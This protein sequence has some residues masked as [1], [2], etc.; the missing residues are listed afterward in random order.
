MSSTDPDSGRAKAGEG[1]RGDV[2]RAW[3]RTK[4]SVAR[5]APSERGGAGGAG[6]GGAGGGAALQP[7]RASSR[8]RSCGSGRACWRAGGDAGSELV[9]IRYGRMLVSPFT[10]Y[11]GAARIMASDLAATPHS[12]FGRRR[13]AM[14]ICRTSACSHRR[15][16]DWCSTSTTSTRRCRGRGS[17]TSSGWRRAWWSRRA[18]TAIHA[19]SAAGSCARRSAATARRCAASPTMTQSGGVVLA[20]GRRRADRPAPQPDVNAKMLEARREDARQGPHARQHAGVL[21]AH[22]GGRRR[23]AD[24]QRPAADRAR[25]GTRART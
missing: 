6:A 22:P 7:R 10:F 9:P 19:G 13:A 1:P 25:R 14:R 20:A 3:A 15:N 8:R 23:A 21:Q 5:G 17:G 4:P 18:R 2:R 16:G 11:R 12:G 24:H